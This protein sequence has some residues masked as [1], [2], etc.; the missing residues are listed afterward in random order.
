M[1]ISVDDPK[2]ENYF[3]TT[4][5][6]SMF[7]SKLFKHTPSITHKWL[8]DKQPMRL[9]QTSNKKDIV[10]AYGHLSMFPIPAYEP[11]HRLKL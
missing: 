9:T 3:G 7:A 10:R 4:F 11:L 2:W 6:L 1:R 8:K 5:S